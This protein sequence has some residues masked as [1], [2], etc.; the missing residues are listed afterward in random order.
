MYREDDLVWLGCLLQIVLFV[1]A[2]A[3]AAW[4]VDYT[5]MFFLGK[6]IPLFWDIVIGTFG[7][8]VTIPVAIVIVILK[9]LEVL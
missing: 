6:D 7:G 4:S 1:I 9:H 3:I 8:Q 2:T 5:L